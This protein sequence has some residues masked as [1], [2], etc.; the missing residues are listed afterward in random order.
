M[1]KE[2]L[3]AIEIKEL[4]DNYKSN[5]RKFEFQIENAKLAISKLESEILLGS[6]KAAEEGKSKKATGKQAVKRGPKPKKAATE[7]AQAAEVKEPKKRGPKPKKAVA[8]AAQAAEVKE[9]KKRGPKPKKAV[10][11]AAQAAEVKKAEKKNK[12]AAKPSGPV[13]KKR[14][15][16]TA[17]LTEWDNFIIQTLGEGKKLR[18][19]DDLHKA[20]MEERDAQKIQEG[21]A[22]LKELLNRSLQKL[23]GKMGQID[24][25]KVPG[26][27]N[28]YGLNSWKDKSGGFP[29]KYH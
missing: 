15:G 22:R 19:N 8:E 18:T 7:A 4:I 27:G 29:K 28:L 14:P 13:E 11:E 10:A 23:S 26:V 21:N 24:K 17:T 25:V 6:T 2:N 1:E 20:M 16:R 5:I 9:P 3:S 12:A